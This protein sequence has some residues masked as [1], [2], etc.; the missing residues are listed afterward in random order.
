MVGPTKKCLMK[1]SI[2]SCELNPR[3]ERVEGWIGAI[4]VHS[5]IEFKFCKCF[6]QIGLVVHIKWTAFF[7]TRH[8]Q[9]LHSRG[10][11]FLMIACQAGGFDNSSCRHFPILVRVFIDDQRQVKFFGNGLD[12]V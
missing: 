12:K 2:P 1:L 5:I 4:N 7:C 6:G 10:F 8:E 3:S 11:E 9:V